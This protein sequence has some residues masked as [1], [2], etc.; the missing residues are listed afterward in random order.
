MIS[1]LG[2][3]VKLINKVYNVISIISN[4]EAFE[5]FFYY[6][7]LYGN[8]VVFH[9]FFMYIRYSFFVLSKAC[10]FSFHNSFTFL[11]AFDISRLKFFFSNVKMDLLLF[12]L[13]GVEKV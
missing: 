4:F 1:G 11:S 2:H 5:S 13:A 6:D 10:F 8:K 9:F 7:Y 3:N 12:F